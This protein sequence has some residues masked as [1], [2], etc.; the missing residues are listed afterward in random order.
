M[1]R[2]VDEKKVDEELNGEDEGQKDD[3]KDDDAKGAR[4]ALQKEIDDLADK[5]EVMVNA[6]GG[7]K[8]TG[9]AG[10]EEVD[11]LVDYSFQVS[12]LD[13]GGGEKDTRTACQ[14]NI[15][16]HPSPLPVRVNAKSTPGCRP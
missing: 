15:D 7:E 8:D 10:Q 2:K 12:G 4:R 6:D 5:P 13:E 11:A 14:K 16:D 1:A 9:T 3:E